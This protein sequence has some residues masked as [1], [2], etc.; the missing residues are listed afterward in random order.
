LHWLALVSI[1]GCVTLNQHRAV[2]DRVATL[3]NQL[4]ELQERL[5]P[6]L[7]PSPEDEA[8]SRGLLESAMTATEELR[9]DDALASLGELVDDYSNTQ[10][11]RIG[12]SLR[13]EVEV[14]GRDAAELEVERWFQGSAADVADDEATLYVFWEVWCPHCQREVPKLSET[15][16]RYREQGLGLVGLTEMTRDVT[17]EQVEE[18]IEDNGVSYPIAKEKDQALARQYGIRGIPA[19]AMVKDGKVVWRGHPAS[20]SDELIDKVL[21]N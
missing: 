8:K 2:E 9:W 15:Y 17:P 12:A 20:L 13:E 6:M 10:A 18:F 16:D 7:P 3:E 1:S 21:T 14:V 5:A 19:A 4:T 11:A